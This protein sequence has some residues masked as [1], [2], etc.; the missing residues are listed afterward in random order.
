MQSGKSGT[1][2]LRRASHVSAGVQPFAWREQA[3]KHDL[4]RIGRDVSDME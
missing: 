4:Q 2:F 1:L 3:V